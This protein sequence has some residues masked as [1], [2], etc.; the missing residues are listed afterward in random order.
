MEDPLK[1]IGGRAGSAAAWVETTAIT[2]IALAA[3]FWASPDDPYFLRAEFPWL[4]LA[5]ALLALRY[6][7]V[8]GVVSAALLIAG[9]MIARQHGTLAGEFPKL[10]FLGSLILVM[11]CGQFSSLWQTRLRRIEYVQRQIDERLSRLTR[12][13]YLLRLSHDRLE[14]DLIGKPVTLRSALSDIRRLI[15]EGGDSGLPGAARLVRLLVQSCQLEVAGLYRNG[16]AGLETAPVAQAGAP[17]ALPAEDPLVASCLESGA[18]AHV[19]GGSA[20]AAESAFL[21]VAPA[22]DSGGR[23]LAVLAVEQM[24]F[25]ALQA[26]NLQTLSVLLGYYA[27]G[28]AR[29]PAAQVVQDLVPSC[30]LG[31]AEELVRLHRIHAAVQVPTTLVALQFGNHP[32]REAFAE[33]LRRSV[34]DFDMVWEIRQGGL[35]VFVVMLP[36][37]GMAAVDGYLLRI[38]GLLQQRF[39]KNLDAARITPYVVQLDEEQPAVTLTLLLEHCGVKP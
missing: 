20:K 8:A 18:L 15:A 4:V 10:H 39:E 16:A 36:L 19:Q 29:V 37:N 25:F 14:Q 31:F 35:H 5:P 23:T 21:V 32:E 27:D 9:W 13:H 28:V 6:G 17:R 30:P 12:R 11:L 38:E 34:R 26:E 22:R 2:L 7:V 33:M 24:P 3:A 1:F